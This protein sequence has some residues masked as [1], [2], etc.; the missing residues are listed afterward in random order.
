MQQPQDSII[1]IEETAAAAER[2]TLALDAEVQALRRGDVASL[3]TS[4][5]EKARL[6]RS[7][8]AKL[9][10]L[11]RVVATGSPI[12]SAARERLE[13]TTRALQKAIDGNVAR[14]RAAAEANRRLVDALARAAADANRRPTYAPPAPMLAAS[15]NQGAPVTVSR[16]L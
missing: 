15:R 9:Q 4:R 7:Y 5:L 2:L 1:A 10:I 3:E 11:K 13:A 6:I 16:Q 12:A 8:E 14:L